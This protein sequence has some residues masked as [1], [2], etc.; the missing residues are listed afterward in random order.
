MSK[1]QNFEK[2]KLN[3]IFILNVTECES[4]SLCSDEIFEL[5]MILFWG[6]LI[7]FLRYDCF[8]KILI[9]VQHRN[10]ILIGQNTIPENKG[11]FFLNFQDTT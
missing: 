10:S 9:Y 5:T 8:N 1:F 3:K 4:S 2:Q 11:E 7:F 6:L